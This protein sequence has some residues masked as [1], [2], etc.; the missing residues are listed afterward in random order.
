V[1]KKKSHTGLYVGLGVGAFCL[2]GAVIFWHSLFDL[3]HTFYAKYIHTEPAVKLETVD[4]NVPPPPP[5]ELATDEILQ[6]V[7]DKYKGL[8][9]YSV[10][11]QAIAAIDISAIR[12]GAAIQNSAQA[13]S[14]ELG[15]TNLYRL[16]WQ[17]TAT[18]QPYKGA[19]WSAGKG[20]FVGY[21]PYPA[22]KM[23]NRETALK[24]ASTA[25]DALCIGLAHLFY[26]DTNSLAMFVEAFAKTNGP[27]VTPKINGHD[28]YVL[29]G[30]LDAHDLVIWVDKGTFLI[31]QIQFIFG[32]KLDD[33]KFKDMRPAD[34]A[35]YTQ[36]SKLK[37][38]IT[39]TYQ[40]PE[41]DKTIAAAS[42]ASEFSPLMTAAD[43]AAAGGGGGQQPARPRQQMRG[44]VP[45]SPTEL[46]RRV[47][48]NQ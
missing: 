2:L 9:T 37:G 18:S 26:D 15:R 20:D 3:G 35:Q 4:T 6:N 30:Q 11:G 22:T 17:T 8:T 14:L 43:T 31:Q 27:N 38:S 41:V 32:G 47:R 28:C 12:P 5:P 40:N 23:R 29:D 25:S 45:T 10:K 24:T 44:A 42:F 16:E 33:A 13:V 19:A 46:T 21:G 36:W 48:P 7:R 1:R 39:E 34:K